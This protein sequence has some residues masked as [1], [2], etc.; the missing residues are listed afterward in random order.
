VWQPI[1]VR[2][3]V[4]SARRRIILHTSDWSR[5]L[6]VSS[7]DRP[8]V[9]RKSGPLRS[10]AMPA[11]AM[12]SSRY[13]KVVVG[14]H[15]VLLA[16]LLVQPNPSP[17]PLHIE[18]LDPHRDSRSHA[19]E[20]VH[21]QADQSPVAQAGKGSGVDRVDQDTRLVHIQDRRLALF[22]CILRPAHYAATWEAALQGCPGHPFHSNPATCFGRF[23]PIGQES[24]SQLP[25][26][27]I[28]G[29]NIKRQR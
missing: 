14:W 22:L 24:I 21:H 8:L 7:P 16:A 12:Y 26:M 6:P 13:R 15:L 4:A 1:S 11:A 17:A 5:E 2:I 28:H 10:S 20:G 25:K 23:P 29:G 9:V 18:V 3:P 19:G 27:P